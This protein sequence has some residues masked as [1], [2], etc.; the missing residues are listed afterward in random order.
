[1]TNP[2]SNAQM[3]HCTAGQDGNCIN[4]QHSAFSVFGFDAVHPPIY[5]PC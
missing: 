3:I 4:Q 1:M 5:L 2:G